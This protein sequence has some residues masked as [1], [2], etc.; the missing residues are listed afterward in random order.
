M[1]TTKLRIGDRVRF[2]RG[3]LYYIV[4]DLCRPRDG[5]LAGVNLAIG[6]KHPHTGERFIGWRDQIRNVKLKK[7]KTHK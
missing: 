7:R 3:R 6:I 5:W 2:A 1:T 4:D